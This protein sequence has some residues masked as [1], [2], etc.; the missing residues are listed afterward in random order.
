MVGAKDAARSRAPCPRPKKNDAWIG[1]EDP[2]SIS[3]MVCRIADFPTPGPP[4]IH[5]MLLNAP[6][7]R[8][9]IH[10]STISSASFRVSGWQRGAGDRSCEFRR[11]SKA[12]IDSSDPRGYET[13]G[14]ASRV[15]LEKLD[16]DVRVIPTIVCCSER[17]KGPS[18]Y[19][20]VIELHHRGGGGARWLMFVHWLWRSSRTTPTSSC[21]E[22]AQV[23]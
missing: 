1:L 11:A 14:L 12:T 19:N 4:L 10:L 20:R 5:I 23:L 18:N 15:L 3:Q 21:L 17:V 16:G 22:A 6:A 9:Q 8:F 13:D 7:P 2:A